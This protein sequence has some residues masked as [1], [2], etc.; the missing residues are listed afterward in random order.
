M[1]VIDL[2]R[3]RLAY[4]VRGEAGAPVVVL[5]HGGGEDSSTWD[6]VVAGLAGDH[7]TVAVDLRGH[8]G[9]ERPGVYSFELMRDDVAALLDALDLTGVALVGHSMGGVV[10]YLLAQERPEL[11]RRLVLEETPPPLPMGFPVPDE[12][13]VRRPIISQLNAPDPVWWQRIPRVTVPTVVIA[14]GEGSFLPQQ[15]LAEMAGRFPH[16]SLVTIPV[17]H[18]VHAQ[19]PQQFLDTIR[20]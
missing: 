9:S 20:G 12:G 14:G 4:R 3:V 15:L 5:L 7:R 6:S 18:R 17:G 8:G 10:A 16:G 1:D 2:G 19:A 11:V 13:E